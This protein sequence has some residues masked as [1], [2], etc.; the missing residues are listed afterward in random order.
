MP[1]K[2]TLENISLSHTIHTIIPNHFPAAFPLHWHK[3]VE[4]L[5]I[6]H[7]TDSP[8]WSKVRLQDSVHTLTPGTILFIWPGELHEILE[9]PQQKMIGIQF[10]PIIFQDL[11]EFASYLQAFRRIHFLSVTEH[12]ELTENMISFFSQMVYLKIT[13]GKFQ[14]V[15]TLIC[16][17]EC[18]MEFANHLSY[19]LPKE[20]L[21]SF[22]K[23]AQGEK[24]YQ[25]CDFITK[26]CQQ[27]LT[28]NFVAKQAGFNP[29][30][31]SRIFKKVSGYNFVEY[32]AIQ[33]IKRAQML[34]ANVSLSMTEIAYQSGFKSISTFNRTFLQQ[35]GCSPSQ[36][37]KYYL[38]EFEHHDL[39]NR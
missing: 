33:R 19:L 31:F 34:L 15:E 29:Y 2:S 37:R 12:T 21:L 30:Y 24:I 14:G 8:A 18:F 1:D 16:L 39:I 35:K 25:I 32:L 27:P 4:I 10:S 26:N 36:Y 5:T 6:P 13:A 23:D 20:Q 28:L 17:Y 38:N 11:P 22:Q 9:N 3:H 7:D